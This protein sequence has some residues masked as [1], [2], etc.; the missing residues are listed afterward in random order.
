WRPRGEGALVGGNRRALEM[1]DVSQDEVMGRPATSVLSQN[2][3]EC[4]V[5]AEVRK[6]KLTVTA[7]QTFGD[8]R[9]VL[10]SGPPT[11]A[12]G[13]ELRHIVLNFRA[14]TG[15]SRGFGRLE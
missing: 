10:L 9:R 14:L 1:L 2:G 4:S 8:G 13:G 11:C 7:V 3:R 5:L 6:Q 15:M 12:G